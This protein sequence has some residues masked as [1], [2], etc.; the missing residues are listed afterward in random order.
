MTQLVLTSNVYNLISII[1]YVVD[2]FHCCAVG[3]YAEKDSRLQYCTAERNQTEAAKN[4]FHTKKSS[5][6]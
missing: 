3:T 5:E 6:S 1:L 4:L 2:V